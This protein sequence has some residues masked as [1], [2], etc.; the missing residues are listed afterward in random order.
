MISYWLIK[1]ISKYKLLQ[2]FSTSFEEV[3][4]FVTPCL[5]TYYDVCFFQRCVPIAPG[6]C[7]LG[8]IASTSPDENTTNQYSTT[9]KNTE[10]ETHS[11]TERETVS[12]SAPGV[13][14]S[15]EINS[16]VSSTISPTSDANEETNNGNDISST[17]GPTSTSVDSSTNNEDKESSTDSVDHESTNESDELSST[18]TIAATTNED[19]VPS[20]VSNTNID[21]ESTQGSDDVSST[22]TTVTTP[23]GK[24]SEGTTAPPICPPGVFGNVPHPDKCNVFY[25]CMGGPP[26]ELSC[27]DGLEFDPVQAVCD[28]ILK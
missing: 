6:G 16:E 9:E 20:T 19:I 25:M 10:E 24:S 17:Q 5:V 21:E 3:F 4:F 15:T 11:P 27:A 18:Q 1:L 14:S 13:E 2:K 7:T 23:D 28:F 26:M 12:E 8:P 22:P